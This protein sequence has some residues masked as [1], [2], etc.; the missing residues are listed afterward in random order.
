[1]PAESSSDAADA[2]GGDE[3]RGGGGPGSYGEWIGGG[4]DAW[5]GDDDVF[6]DELNPD[7]GPPDGADEFLNDLPWEL[8]EEHM[9]GP[10]TGAGEAMAAGFLH[11]GRGRAGT[12]FAAGGALDRLSPGPV[13]AG[14]A[15]EAWEGGLAGLGES[16]LVGLLC[17]WRRL[18]SWAA[19]GEV[20]AVITLARR[21]AVQARERKSPALIDHVGDEVAAA[22]TLTGRGGSRVVELAGNLARLEGTLAALAEGV[23]DWPRA[24]VIADEL[25]VLDDADARAAEAAVLSRAGGLTTGA[26]RAA[27]RRAVEAVDP[28]AAGRRRRAARKEAGVQIWP[29]ASGNSC[30][31]GRELP[32]AEAVAADSRLTAQARWLKERGAQGTIGQLRQ[33]VFSALLGGRPVDSLLPGP[34]DSGRDRPGPGRPAPDRPAGGGPAAGGPATGA[35]PAGGVGTGGSAGGAPAGGGVGTCGPP[36]PPG[37]TAITGTV[38]LIMPLAAWEGRSDAPGEVPGFGT[39][40]AGT[41]RDLARSLAASPQARWCVTITDGDGRAVAHACARQGPG[42]PGA[43]LSAGWLAGQRLQIL[44]SGTCGH[45]RQASGYVP[46]RSLR[47]LVTTRRRTCGFPG[48]RRPAVRCDVD[49]T[50]PYDQ[51]GRTCECNLAPLCRWHHQAKQAP[52]WHLDQPRPGVLTWTLPHGRRYTTTP[53]PY[54]V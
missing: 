6:G 47:H 46:P 16:E 54:P 45:G 2:G 7:T 39:A 9:T 48:C 26:L 44:E 41:C 33:A 21:R 5:W 14:F 17:G 25:S 13:L 23:I 42:P 4:D 52:G 40:D 53:D 35:P 1:V 36:G 29:E 28:A 43:P 37:W 8:R 27:L 49:H 19:A 10:W 30:L 3:L 51:G 11:H 22:L 12:G 18:A 32:P 24:M 50:I 15:A 31:A 20:A 34:A 38:N